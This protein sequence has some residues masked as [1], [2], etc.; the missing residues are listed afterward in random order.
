MANN[1]IELATTEI[2]NVLAQCNAARLRELPV[3]TQMVALATGIQQLRKVLNKDLVESTF[4]PLQGSALGFITDRDRDGGY[5]GQTVR[6]CMIEGLIHGLRP[7]G[8]EINIIS[9]RCY[10]TK[11]GYARLVSE[12]EGLTDL[13]LMPGVPHAAGD[14]ALV[15]FT[16]RWRLNG[17]PDQIVLEYVKRPDGSI[18]DTR[19]AVKVN[20]GMGADAI[21]GK[22]ERKM[23]KRIH[24]RLTGSKLSLTDGDAMDTTGV[25]VSEPTPP[26]APPEQDGRR[27]SLG[28][29]K[30][31][32]PDMETGELPMR[33]PGEEG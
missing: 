24:T 2:E 23:L 25:A 5:D 19:I 13:E 9:G 26:L 27:M 10:A 12:F 16:A 29:K 14:G 22:A 15:P 28:A 6:D 11:N 30:T 21:L 8:N 32:E 31:E 3:L 1:S 20:K 33:E 7:V 4:M 17:K 18:S